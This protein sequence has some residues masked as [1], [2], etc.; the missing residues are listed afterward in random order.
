M[1]AEKKEKGKK[2]KKL[3]YF[4]DAIFELQSSKKKNGHSPNRIFSQ[5]HTGK[6]ENQ[7]SHL[8]WNWTWQLALKFIK[9]ETENIPYFFSNSSND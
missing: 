3:V 1:C 4:C 2:R 5:N 6:T 8:K 9:I 7:K